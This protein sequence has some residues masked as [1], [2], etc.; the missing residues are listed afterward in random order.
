MD[1]NLVFKTEHDCLISC[2]ENSWLN[3]YLVFR[4]IFSNSYFSLG[5]CVFDHREKACHTDDN[6][7]QIWTFDKISKTCFQT[8]SSECSSL[9]AFTSKVDCLHQCV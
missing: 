9:N 4:F 5:K 2:V 1:K 3:N 8:W 6:Y 7:K